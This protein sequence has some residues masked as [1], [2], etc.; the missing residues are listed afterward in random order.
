[1]YV[2]WVICHRGL[3]VNMYTNWICLQ[4]TQ[5]LKLK[6]IQRI[7]QWNW[8]L[9]TDGIFM[10][11]THLPSERKEAWSEELLSVAEAYCPAEHNCTRMNCKKQQVPARGAQISKIMVAATKNVRNSTCEMRKTKIVLVA[12]RNACGQC[13]NWSLIYLIEIKITSSRENDLQIKIN[14]LKLI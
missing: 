2:V 5:Q 14:G 6:W 10:R 13:C 3:V 7:Y 8:W 1:M 11:S 4:Q 9:E 12:Q